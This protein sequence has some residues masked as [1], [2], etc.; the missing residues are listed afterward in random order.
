[1]TDVLGIPDLGRPA[2]FKPGLTPDG[3][4]TWAVGY[5]PHRVAVVWIGGEGLSQR[6]AQGLWT[7]IMQSAS[8]DVPPDGWP[9]PAG[10]LRLKVCD[11]SGLLP[12]DACPNVVDE[13][14]IDGYQPVQTDT[15]YRA[16]AIN[17]ET[18]FLATVF[19]PPQLVEQRVY[20]QV[21]PEAQTWARAASLP[22]PPTQY[23][24]LQPPAPD[25]GANLTSPAMFAE[26]TG[27]VTIS[28]T[29]GGKD[30]AFYRLQYGQGLNPETWV[31]IGADVKSPVNGGKLAEW[32]TS[33]LQGLYAL[34]LLVVRADH[35]LQTATVQVTINHP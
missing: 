10:V 14:F 29:A 30:F 24:T 9:Q 12:T 15:L 2:A 1:V 18:G 28:G 19:T 27:K 34:Q 23:D 7:S 8:R 33:G 21:P 6:P 16:Y 11:P 25:P 13:V 22:V 5:T 17:R 26:L 4:E 3:A 20:M 35:S 31:Q 32:D